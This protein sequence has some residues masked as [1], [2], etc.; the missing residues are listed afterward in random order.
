[1]KILLNESN[2][3]EL[4]VTIKRSL[5][6]TIIFALSSQSFAL[7]IDW[8]GVLGFD[9]TIVDGYRRVDSKVDNSGTAGTQEVALATG[10]TENGNWQNYV[11]RLMPNIVINDSASIKAELSNGYGRGGFIGNNSTQSK[12][13]GVSNQLYPYNFS[14]GDDSLSVNQLYAELYSDTATYVIG[15]HAQHF[16]LGAVINSGENIW[17]RFFYLRDGLTIKVKLGNFKLEPYWTRVATGNSLSKGTRIKDYGISLVYDSIERDLAFGIL[18]N[19]KTTTANSTDYTS[20]ITGTSQTLNNGDVK[21]TD[22]YLK[23]S[24]GNFDIGIEVPI[25]SGE[26]GNLFGSGVTKYK[27]KAYILETHYKTSGSWSFSLLAGMVSGD[28]GVDN[29]FD[30]MY[31]NPNYQV[32]NLL[33]RYNLQAVA[34]NNG[35]SIYDSYINNAT[36]VKLG[37]TYQSEK[38]KWDIAGIWAKADQTAKAGTRSYNHLTNKTFTANYDQKDDLGLELDTGFE[39]KWNSE[40][41]VGANLGYLFTGKYFGYTNTA[42]ENEV[43]NSYVLQLRTAISF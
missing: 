7:P 29:S 13:S 15:R 38:W 30:A 25:L 27:A 3:K 39:Y 36:Y 6:A 2:P 40:V 22:L 28:D 31:L 34:N 8:H 16:G 11:F 4:S 26:L 9:T 24:F 43:N 32:A 12:D 35:Y 10:G 17:D 23:K 18:Y 19:K 20:D 37:S 14:S 42:T 1:M 5:L 41:T 33:F 21:L